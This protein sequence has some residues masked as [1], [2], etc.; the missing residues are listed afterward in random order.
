[1]DVLAVQ[2]NIVAAGKRLLRAGLTARTWGNVS[3]RVSSEEFA[4][5]PSGRSYEGL[6]PTDIPILSIA[7][8]KYSGIHAG[9]YSATVR[10]SSEKAV[11]AGI[12][13]LRPNISFIIHTHQMYASVASILGQS[14]PINNEKDAELIGSVIPT[15]A[16][17]PAGTKSIARN[18]KKT[19]EDYPVQAVLLAH[20]GAVCFAEQADDAF[21]IAARIEVI[22]R[23][24]IE[25]KIA[26]CFLH[27]R[28]YS[29]VHLYPSRRH[30]LSCVLIEPS[31]HAILC[32][33]DLRSGCIQSG[34]FYPVVDLHA[35]IY[36]AMAHIHFIV[37]SSTP[38]TLLASAHLMKADVLPP[39]IEDFAQIAG[40]NVP[41]FHFSENK[42]DRLS[43]DLVYALKTRSAVLFHNGGV[44]CCG[45]SFEDAQAVAAIVEKNALAYILA[46]SVGDALPLTAKAAAD[47]RKEYVD[48]YSKRGG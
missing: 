46:Q 30:G 4:I 47:L 29:E 43:E 37:Q 34:E 9:M 22:A 15:A 19:L 12:Y 24:A 33:M 35:A 10:P 2:T 44:L 20:H 5:T 38:Y 28:A 16:Y 41:A 25:K 36:T 42:I 11:H 13:V 40:V 23:A 32:K 21:E 7:T 17:A 26:A 31:S 3:A 14:L 39:F 45:E 18:V 1:M 6:H 8:L 27:K 48:D